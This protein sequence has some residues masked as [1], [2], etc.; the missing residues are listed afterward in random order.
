MSTLPSA[1]PI[2]DII[3]VNVS[4][5]SG[6][7]APRPFN[8]G[9]IVGSS[10]VIPSYGANA[11]IRQYPSLAAMLADGFTSSEPEYLAAQLYF[12]Q[13]PAP[14][15]V[16]IGRQ[17]LTAIQTAIPHTGNAGTGYVVG[18]VVGVTQSGGSHGFLTVLTVGGSGNVTSLGTT[19]G[20]QGTGYATATA[21][22]TTGGTGTGL[23]V[24]ITAIGETC[25]QAVEACYV[26][27]NSW[28][29]FMCCGAV[30]ADHLALAAF[31]TANWQTVLYFGS[32]TDAAI[33]AG[34]TGN[35][36]LQMKAA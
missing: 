8:Q 7:I 12:S 9:L 3:V 6:A 31:S 25:L 36:A 10:A 18:D 16:W 15:E 28:Y 34:T 13:S 4:V 29:P 23:E 26:V 24:D 17:D 2:S 33:P 19:V 22:A 1:L 5:A 20:S 21:L 11:R 14:Q 30:D 32:S 35:L 27:N